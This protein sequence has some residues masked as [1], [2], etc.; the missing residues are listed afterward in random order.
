MSNPLNIQHATYKTQTKHLERISRGNKPQVVIKLVREAAS[1]RQPCRFRFVKS[2]T[3]CCSSILYILS[4]QP[5][6][7]PILWPLFLVNQTHTNNKT[8]H[9]VK[10]GAKVSTCSISIGPRTATHPTP[11]KTKKP[12][13]RKSTYVVF[14]R[15]A[16]ISCFQFRQCTSLYDA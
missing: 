1:C 5:V 9:S 3:L 7:L 4:I 16:L 12:A 10:V 11:A 14:V 13:N 2:S 8:P 6:L 15:A